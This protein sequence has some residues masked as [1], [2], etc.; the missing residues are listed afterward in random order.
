M[1]EIPGEQFNHISWQGIPPS[2]DS[3]VRL[4]RRNSTAARHDL[5]RTSVDIV[6]GASGVS[7]S[8]HPCIQR[9]SLQETIILGL[10]TVGIRNAVSGKYD[11]IPDE[12][13]TGF[14]P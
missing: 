6:A 9:C 1:A 2:T 12:L 7:A 11:D 14:W 3:S 5:T 13:K 4:A 10:W 8:P